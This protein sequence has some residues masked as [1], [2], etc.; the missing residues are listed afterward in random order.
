MKFC[1]VRLGLVRPA[2]AGVCSPLPFGAPAHRM[3]RAVRQP[4]NSPGRSRAESELADDRLDHFPAPVRGVVEKTSPR[5]LCLRRK[6]G[7]CAPGP[8]VEQPIA[9]CSRVT[10]CVKTF[11][12]YLWGRSRR[13]LRQSWLSNPT[14]VSKRYY[15]GVSAGCDLTF[16]V[17]AGRRGM[18]RV[19]DRPAT[20]R[21]PSPG[22]A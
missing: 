21:H 5:L 11:L 13:L 3:E 19:H 2:G 18:T 22:A 6:S 17:G 12:P 10:Q 1:H 9:K 7:R 14:G 20:D 15:R 4:C 8:A 16:C